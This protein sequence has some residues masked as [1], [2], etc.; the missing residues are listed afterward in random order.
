MTR[1]RLAI[2]LS[3]VAVGA[4]IAVAAWPKN[5]RSGDLLRAT[6]TAEV[7]AASFYI[8]L[9]VEGILEAARSA[10]IV[11]LASETQIVFMLAD[12]LSV[13]RGQV[14]LKLNPAETQ[15]RVDQLLTQVA[16]SEEKVRQAQAEGEKRVQ[17]AR[18]A[19]AKATEALQLARVQAR[20]AVEKAEAEVAFL[21]KE[22]GVA[23]GQL[24]KR[25]RL[26]EERLLSITEVEAAEDE[27]RA[28]KFALE[29]ARRSLGR[30]SSDAEA[31]ESLRQMDVR[32]AKIEL[33][34]AEGSL[35]SSVSSA[36]RDLVSNQLNLE[37]AQEQLDAMEVKAPVAGM[38]LLE[39]TWED[40]WR[41]LRVGDQVWEGQRL[42]RI[43][44]PSEMWVRCDINEA[45]I[46][47][48]K[49]GQHALVRVPAIGPQTLE[50]EIQ[51]IDNL[52]R[53]RSPWEGGVPGKKVFAAVVRL[54]T[55]EPEL[56]P[57]MGATVEIV[58]E[59]VDEG[60]SVPLEALFPQEGG[61]RVYVVEAHGYREVP[62]QLL[63]RSHAVAAIQGEVEIGDV[64]LRERPPAALVI[65]A[66][67]GKA[68]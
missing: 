16:E 54:V 23:E 37:E 61:Y 9:P 15:K 59:H 30:A 20:A 46:E 1:K 68:T 67:E 31:T 47:R 35:S 66:D 55:E 4:F 36:E 13:D 3:V 58:L 22:L 12:G 65:P 44:D 29:A 43:I 21:E 7:S 11:N 33:E 63:K 48:V 17:N 26:L 38:L 49:V 2:L 56:R 52:A 19:L 40:G 18:G 27:V 14:V 41:P 10:P 25:K 32:T 57:G 50:G 45:D 8:T 6:Q 34:Q 51:A 5:E 62:V 53:Q 64:V 28:R 60:L 39:Q 42:A 24:E